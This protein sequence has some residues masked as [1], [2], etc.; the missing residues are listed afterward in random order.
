M[1]VIL[2]YNGLDSKDPQ[3]VIIIEWIKEMI[4]DRSRGE[5]TPLRFV[6]SVEV[7]G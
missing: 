1:K 2:N 4:A 3:S 6:S 7:E 5:S